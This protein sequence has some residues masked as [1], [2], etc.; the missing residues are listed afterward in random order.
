MAMGQGS[1]VTTTFQD[2][3]A[4]A[5]NVNVVFTPLSTPILGIGPSIY[6]LPQSVIATNGYLA[7]KF[8]YAGNYS[9]S[10]GPQYDTIFIGVTN[11]L[12]TNDLFAAQT[13]FITIYTNLSFLTFNLGA[14][15]PGANVTVVTNTNAFGIIYYTVSSSG[16]GGSAPTNLAGASG[17]ILLPGPTN[18]FILDTN[19]VT[20]PPHFSVFE[21]QT[22]LF[23]NR[24]NPIFNTTNVVVAFIGDSEWNSSQGAI[25]QGFSTS[26]E[27]YLPFNSGYGFYAS[28][29]T[30]GLPVIST[31]V[32]SY[33]APD[34]NWYGAHWL[35]PQGGSLTN[36]QYCQTE[37]WLNCAGADTI[38][39]AYIAGPTE[40][41]NFQIQT[42]S[43]PSG[44]FG[45]P[46][47]VG[48]TN[49]ICTINASNTTRVGILTNI[50]I[51]PTN[52]CVRIYNVGSQPQNINMM[53]ALVTKSGHNYVPVDLALGGQRT[54]QITNV[55]TNVFFPI[56]SALDPA[57]ILI[58]DHND[59]ID[60]VQLGW[61]NVISFLTN[62]TR[63][64]CEV[65][66]VDSYQLLQD[67]NGGAPAQSQT[68]LLA[69]AMRSNCIAMVS[70]FIDTYFTMPNALAISNAQWFIDG[71]H[72]QPYSLR[73]GGIIG[74][75]LLANCTGIN[76]SDPT[77]FRP[78]QIDLSAGIFTSSVT[79]TNTPVGL[80][81][82]QTA[83]QQESEMVWK[84]S[85]GYGS[86]FWFAKKDT[87]PG[88]PGGSHS[89]DWVL[90]HVM[91][92]LGSNDV[93]ILPSINAIALSDYL[94]G[95][96]RGAT[97]A[98]AAMLFDTRAQVIPGGVT[99]GS[100]AVTNS[101]PYGLGISGNNGGSII[102][103]TLR[104]ANNPGSN[105]V[106][107]YKDTDPGESGGN[108]SSGIAIGANIN[109]QTTNMLS[110][111][112]QAGKL[113]LDRNVYVVS[114]LYV[115]GTN[116]IT[117]NLPTATPT[118]KGAVLPDGN[119]SHALL[120]DG[121]WGGLVPLAGT[122]IV[123]VGST[124][125]VS[126]AVITNQDVNLRTNLNGEVIGSVTDANQT[127]LELLGANNGFLQLFVQNTNSGGAN[128]SGD[129]V[130]GNDNDLS[131]PKGTG[132]YADFGING[133]H[134]TGYIGGSNDVYVYG[135]GDSNNN[136]GTNVNVIIAA[137]QTNS[138]I[139][140]M[141]GNGTNNWAGQVS[142][143]TATFTNS[144]VQSNLVWWNKG[145]SNQPMSA[146]VGIGPDGKTLVTN[147]Y[148][149]GSQT[150]WTSDINGAGYKL[151]NADTSVTIS[152]MPPGGSY[153]WS[154]SL[155]VS[156][157]Y[158]P[159][160]GYSGVGAAPDTTD[161]NANCWVPGRHFITTLIVKLT[162]PNTNTWTVF[163]NGIQV[164]TLQTSFGNAGYSE[165][166]I[167]P[168]EIGGPVGPGGEVGTWVSIQANSTAAP[169]SFHASW[170]LVNTNLP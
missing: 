135:Q 56:M 85:L 166:S 121:T 54:M 133:S 26:I 109:G 154:S 86:N 132:W 144:E 49:V 45:N 42:V 37:G 128:A 48:V 164:A 148:S 69:S 23:I 92:G 124:V 150:P 15:A 28:S 137:P 6:S 68:V 112:A 105:F 83:G 99:A 46:P 13:N 127:P 120:G 74:Q 158:F 145:G 156:T 19:F 59:A 81:I 79:V 75:Q 138:V 1:W 58:G 57:V 27:Q 97:N 107:F 24:M 114:G 118:T 52:V 35:V 30:L 70:P 90:G 53:A 165:T 131:G 159:Y 117:N 84:T 43:I 80:T 143:Y 14:V 62:A 73:M 98:N 162:G 155:N 104:T 20:L 100:L 4:N 91:N 32:T 93:I 10:F 103:W 12:S 153:T 163:T 77:Y 65:V 88:E 47:P 119:A 67:I 149:G 44:V 55:S 134:F 51:S 33:A 130:I 113:F 25:Q 71:I 7:P 63:N 157:R 129:V 21:T 39:V 161:T 64:T 167:A 89:G 66:S 115:G 95:D 61:S 168:L 22:P 116:N 126:S 136:P 41:T 146:V 106:F 123:V 142:N 76:F 102:G 78:K 125:S 11:N 29:S 2:S 40:S 87:D 82:G 151:T 18:T 3:G 9:V 17:V 60:S 50:F 38:S 147:A 72:L 5:P 152:A 94:L 111:N 170:C 31:G 141:A 122:N 34:T 101:G 139:R 8:L 169:S 96:I 110:W 16:G 160:F 140:F 108:Q 36:L